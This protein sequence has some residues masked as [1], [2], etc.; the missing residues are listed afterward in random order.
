MI[1]FFVITFIDSFFVSSGK[2]SNIDLTQHQSAR[3]V[4]SWKR[5][6]SS[7]VRFLASLGGVSFGCSAVNSS[8]K[9]DTSSRPFWKRNRK[10]NTYQFSLSCKMINDQT[11]GFSISKICRVIFS[12][13]KRLDVQVTLKSLI[14]PPSQ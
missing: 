1:Y 4:K 14:L 7:S 13:G 11:L 9:F 5:S 6:C 8:S 3:K 2:M 12:V 10:I